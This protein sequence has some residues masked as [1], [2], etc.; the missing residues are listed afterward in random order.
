[1]VE[2]TGPGLPQE[3]QEH[4]FEQFQESIDL[5]NQGTGIGLYICRQLAELLNAKI[6]LDKSYDSG[7]PSCPGACFIIDLQ[8]PP[9]EKDIS[10]HSEQGFSPNLRDTPSL[11]D[12]RKE[13]ECVLGTRLQKD[14]IEPLPSNDIEAQAKG[15]ASTPKN[16]GNNS[17]AMGANPSP[18]HGHDAPVAADLP[19]NMKILFVDDDMVLR[20]LFIR[21]V[22]RVAP[23]WD[24]QEAA[25]GEAA[26]QMVGADTYDVVFMDNYMPGSVERPL[27]GT[28]TVHRL[29]TS[30]VRSIICGL[31]ANDM[32]ESFLAAGADL[33]ML[34][35]FPCKKDELQKELLRILQYP[36]RTFSPLQSSV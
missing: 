11:V 16:D 14:R 19:P 36:S 8:R 29:R 18:T 9:L 4:L 23:G 35:P 20:K 12:D 30:G 3:K 17:D 2:D 27:L 7:I 33:F 24:I 21:S 10:F 28:E 34:K 6:F 1:M 31:S 22:R 5:L 32:E 13:D 25:S 26:L 15:D